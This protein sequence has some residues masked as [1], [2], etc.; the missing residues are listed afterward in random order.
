MGSL[1]IAIYRGQMADAMPRGVPPDA[2]RVAQD[3]LAGALTVAAQLS[4]EV[5]ASLVDAARI[6]YSSAFHAAALVSSVITIGLAVLVAIRLR[7]P[8]Q[9]LAKAASDLPISKEKGEIA[10][11]PWHQSTPVAAP[12]ER[13]RRRE[14][15]SAVTGTSTPTGRLWTWGSW[16]RIVGVA[17][18]DAALPWGGGGRWSAIDRA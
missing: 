9:A 3:T 18:T 16:Q 17:R 1:G 13:D 15:Q 8:G 4:D 2:A 7:K 5:A 14:S 6:S 11:A 12:S 10:S